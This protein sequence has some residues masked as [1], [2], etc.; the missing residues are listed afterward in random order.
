ME[1]PLQFHELIRHGFSLSVCMIRQIVKVR[2][3]VS[4]TAGIHEPELALDDWPREQQPWRK[5]G[6]SL[7]LEIDAGEEIR[8]AE[9][10]SIAHELAVNAHDAAGAFAELRRVTRKVRVDTFNSFQRNS[11]RESPA[12][13]IRQV[14]SVHLIANLIAPR[15]VN[16]NLPV[17]I[18][19]D[20]GHEGKGVQKVALTGVLK[21]LDD[22]FIDRVLRCNR[23]GVDGIGTG[24]NFDRL[25][26]GF[27]RSQRELNRFARFE[28]DL[29][30]GFEV[31]FF[32]YRNP[33]GAE[34]HAIE[35]ESAIFLRYG[36]P[37]LPVCR[38]LDDDLDIADGSSIQ[39]ED[40]A[41]QRQFLTCRQPK[42]H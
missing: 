7:L 15:A 31:A 6:N 42:N 38:V 5:I 36:L 41:A 25:F 28:P 34:R 26:Q 20:A 39:I 9:S 21:S 3:N 19:H 14:H 4:E 2:P 37:L 27:H 23:I 30:R 17:V 16:V 12:R 32:P 40:N 35:A 10:I 11:G 18:A 22:L 24:N 33:V 13:S 1:V 8:K 29:R